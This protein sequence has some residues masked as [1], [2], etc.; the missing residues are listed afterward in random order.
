MNLKAYRK[1]R[2]FKKTKEPSGS[3]NKISERKA[4]FV[5]QKHF[6]RNLH[7]DFRLEY[8]GVLLSWAIPKGPP[9]TKGMKRLAI[10]VEDHPIEYAQFEGTIPEGEYGAGKVEI[11]D[12]G[13]YEIRQTS[14]LKNSPITMS[15]SFRKG[16]ISLSLFGRKLKGNYEF[17]RLKGAERKK[18]WILMKS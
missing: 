15:A 3:N 14:N 6:A 12:K 17:I 8:R 5:V 4:R 10:H 16:H 9:K 1:K 7:Y 13:S 2:N 18:L 11:W